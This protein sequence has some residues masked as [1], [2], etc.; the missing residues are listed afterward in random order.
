MT[1]GWRCCDCVLVIT[2]GT[3]S[4]NLNKLYVLLSVACSVYIFNFI[5]FSSANVSK[6]HWAVRPK[7]QFNVSI[8]RKSLPGQNDIIQVLFYGVNPALSL[9]YYL[10]LCI[11]AQ[12]FVLVKD[13]VDPQ[14]VI[15]WPRHHCC[16]NISI[17]KIRD[18]TLKHRHC[19]YRV[20]QK[21]VQS[22]YALTSSNINR[23]SQSLSESGENL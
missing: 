2:N 17:S 23:F 16:G 11:L 6:T 8:D 5:F 13:C 7:P 4:L 12:Q 21:M 19:H 1:S 20:A 10:S 18:V 3:W 15:R 9:S 14:K 22:L